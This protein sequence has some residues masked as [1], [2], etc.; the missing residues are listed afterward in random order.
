MIRC[1]RNLSGRG[2]A[3]LS[4]VVESSTVNEALKASATRPI[5]HKQSYLA[6]TVD[7]GR[8]GQAALLGLAVVVGLFSS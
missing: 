2:Q 8:V 5:E 3:S 1:L 4:V 6:A 7:C